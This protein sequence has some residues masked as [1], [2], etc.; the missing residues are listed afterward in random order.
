MEKVDRATKKYIENVSKKRAAK[1][2]RRIAKEEKISFVFAEYYKEL[3]T[4]TFV[5]GFI[6]GV[7]A[8]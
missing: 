5:I 7:F 2:E 4:L 3:T 6:L 1:A 8:K